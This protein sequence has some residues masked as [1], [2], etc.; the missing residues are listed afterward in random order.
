MTRQAMLNVREVAEALGV[1]VRTAQR[2]L[3][4]GELVGCKIRRQ[5]RVR[6]MD[7]EEYR[8]HRNNQTQLKP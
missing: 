4:S 7:L 5:W 6:P 2:L 1:H 8:Q 3:Q